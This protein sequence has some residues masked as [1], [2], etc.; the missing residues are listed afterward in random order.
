MAYKQEMKQMFGKHKY[1]GALG[2]KEG[3]DSKKEGWDHIVK[4]H[5]LP[6]LGVGLLCIG[7]SSKV[8]K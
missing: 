5:Y 1:A 3:D 8:F 6:S 7:K 4:N 2:C